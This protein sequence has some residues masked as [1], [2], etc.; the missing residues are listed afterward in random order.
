MEDYHRDELKKPDKPFDPLE[1]GKVKHCD[2]F[3]KCLDNCGECLF[4][5]LYHLNPESWVAPNE[6]SYWNL[7]DNPEHD[8]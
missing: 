5:A 4:N 6:R 8:G 7:A 1:S 3:D 2:L